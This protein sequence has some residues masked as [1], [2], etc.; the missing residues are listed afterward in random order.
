MPTGFIGY[1]TKLIPFN[2]CKIK[3]VNYIDFSFLIAD[4]VYLYVLK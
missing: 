4:S 1:F 2:L 3:N